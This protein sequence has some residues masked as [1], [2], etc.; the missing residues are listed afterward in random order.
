MFSAGRQ[1]KLDDDKRQ[2]LIKKL[3]EA[4]E[5]EDIIL[6][7]YI[8]GSFMESRVFRDIDIAIYLKDIARKV[9]LDYELKLE[10]K[11]EQKVGIP[12]DLRVLNNAPPSF[13]YMVIKKGCK[14]AIHD[15]HKRVEFES[16]VI[17]E[18]LD[19]LPH[20]ERLLREIINA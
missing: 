9:Q 6:F 17:K 1:Y 10:G 11:L 2:K 3:R 16:R 15:D 5:S 13:C 19:F 4:L 14:V 7:A 8:H 18:Y 12:V 20:R